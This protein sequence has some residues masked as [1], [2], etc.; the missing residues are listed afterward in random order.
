MS[1]QQSCLAQPNYGYDMVVS[2]TQKALNNTLKIYYQDA[3][4]KF[5]QQAFYYV[6]DASGN[7]VAIDKASLLAQ[8]GNIDPLTVTASQTSAIQTLAATPFYFAFQF[9]PGDPTGVNNFNYLTINPGTDSVLYYL[10]CAN[11]QV[12]FWNPDTKAWVNVTQSRANEFNINATINL[13]NVLDNSNLPAAVKAEVNNLG[14]TD[15][16]VQQLIFDF[17]SAVVNPTTALPGLDSKGSVFKPLMQQFAAAYFNAYSAVGAPVLNYAVTQQNSSSLIP[18][19][20]NIYANALVDANGKPITVNPTIDQADL[21]TI[22]YLFSVNGDALPAAAQFNWN[23]LEDNGGNN[24]TPDLDPNAD[25]NQ[26]SGSV[27]IKREAFG[28]YL[29]NQLNEYVIGNDDMVGN[30]WVPIIV[31]IKQPDHDEFLANFSAGTPFGDPLQP[32]S[33][34][35]DPGADR[36]LSY[37]FSKS[38]T[39]PGQVYSGDYM[40]M[41]TFFVLIV[42]VAPNTLT[43]TQ[44]LYLSIDAEIDWKTYSGKPVDQEYTD[45]FNITVDDNGCIAFVK[46][47]SQSTASDNS[48][49]VAL[50]GDANESVIQFIKNLAAKSFT[51]VPFSMPKQF[52]F[53]GG[54]AFTFKDAQFSHNS[55]LVCHVN[56][57]SE[58]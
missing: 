29:E 26:Y 51:E 54:N 37:F 7:A 13:E 56:Y 25:V 46:D 6:K 52:V 58:S 27:A 12:V 30:C 20:M 50:P 16:N 9:T 33:P 1:I 35:I 21:S 17:D 41:E 4:K 42:D 8:T 23:W 28:R 48:V 44:T 34:F 57:L 40:T 38:E 47:E 43:I 14:N 11:I 45:V 2:V 22:N 32:Y 49:A 15:V 31:N 5:T 36:L 39:V 53:P 10:L 55:D 3:A 19:K 18:T 24:P